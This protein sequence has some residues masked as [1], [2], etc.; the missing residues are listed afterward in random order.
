MA[1]F[2]EASK[3][4]QRTSARWRIQ[5]TLDPSVRIFA[6]GCLSP[7]LAFAI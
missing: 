5:P 3:Q 4:N 7:Q 1:E 2:E 6:G